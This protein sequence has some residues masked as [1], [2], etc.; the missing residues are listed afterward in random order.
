MVTPAKITEY[1]SKRQFA[2]IVDAVDLNTL[3]SLSASP[4]LIAQIAMASY[5]SGGSGGSQLS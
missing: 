1:F 2:E 5:F 4:D 3:H